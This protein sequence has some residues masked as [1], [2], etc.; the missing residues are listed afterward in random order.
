MSYFEPALHSVNLKFQTLRLSGFAGCRSLS[1]TTHFILSILLRMRH[2]IYHIGST[3]QSFIKKN[4]NIYGKSNF[5]LTL[6]H[7]SMVLGISEKDYVLFEFLSYL[8]EKALSFFLINLKS[9]G[10]L[11]DSNQVN[12]KFHLDCVSKKAFF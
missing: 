9:F 4:R 7:F 2:K 5:A 12:L 6:L 11:N 3:V 10:F 1:C 8:N